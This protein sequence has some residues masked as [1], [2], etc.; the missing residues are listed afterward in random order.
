MALLRFKNQAPNRGFTFMQGETRLWLEG[1][2]LGELVKKVKDHRQH[3]GLHP[4]DE[5]SIQLEVE[6]QICA[7][8][9]TNDCIAEGPDD[10]WAPVPVD[11]NVMNVDK[12]LSFSRSALEWIKGGGQLVAIEEAERRASICRGCPSNVDSGHGCFNCAMTKIISLAVP[13]SRRLPDLKICG[14]CGCDLQS[15]V[16]MPDSVIVASDVG[17]NITFPTFCWQRQIL[18]KNRIGT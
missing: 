10:D 12:I 11:S 16:N 7:R 17:R 13:A 6:R 5:A 2:S 15:K 8:L 9:G 18:E 14:H 1:K 3:K 4:Q